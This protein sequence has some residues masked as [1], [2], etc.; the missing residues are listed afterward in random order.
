[1]VNHL[2]SQVSNPGGH[3]PLS[4]LF[5]RVLRR[6]SRHPISHTEHP[7]IQHLA[8][9]SLGISFSSHHCDNP[10][11]CSVFTKNVPAPLLST[12]YHQVRH[13]SFGF[14]LM[15]SLPQPA[16]PSVSPCRAAKVPQPPIL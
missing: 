4:T 6:R 15:P 9:P 14:Q 8:R 13:I 12:G 3:S 10:S 1:M 5:A 2:F 7:C 11:K 16:P